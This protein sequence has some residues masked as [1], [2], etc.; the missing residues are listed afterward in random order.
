MGIFVS[1]L[2]GNKI[3]I[4]F[5]VSCKTNTIPNMAITSIPRLVDG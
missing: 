2:I 5:V 3:T 1:V 4:H